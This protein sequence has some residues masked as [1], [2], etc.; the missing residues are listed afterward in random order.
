MT[1]SGQ[2]MPREHGRASVEGVT[3]IAIMLAIGGAAG[4]ASFTHVHDVAAMQGQPGWLAWADAVVLELMSVASGLE[5]RRRKRSHTSVGFP[6]AVLVVA[7]TLSLSAQVV[8]AEAS[9]IGW[10]AAAIPALGFLVM[11]KIALA[12]A[13]SQST[14]ASHVM[15][16]PAAAPAPDPVPEPTVVHAKAVSSS[17]GDLPWDGQL[18]DHVHQPEGA[19]ELAV[20][21]PAAAD[22]E[23]IQAARVAAE[24]LAQE[25]RRVSRQA[26]ADALRV[27]GHAVSNARASQLLLALKAEALASGD[28]ERCRRFE[29]VPRAGRLPIKGTGEVSGADLVEGRSGSEAP[30]TPALRA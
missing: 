30:E 18:A 15:D 7:M 4:A 19:R 23:L 5:M 28:V 2:G 17:V 20:D 24:A 29:P 16:R 25:S 13:P 1:A 6:A 3:Q 27:G 14:A 8:D 21:P 9:A 12:Q 22:G 26:L 11:V 10:I